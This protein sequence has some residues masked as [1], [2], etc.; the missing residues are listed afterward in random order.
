MTSVHMR[1]QKR[2]GAGGSS[3]PSGVVRGDGPVSDVGTG[4]CRISSNPHRKEP[5]CCTLGRGS[6]ARRAAELWAEAI[7]GC[8]HTREG[9]VKIC[10]DEVGGGKGG[11]FMAS[12]PRDL[13]LRRSSKVARL[14]C[15][16]F[17]KGPDMYPLALHRDRKVHRILREE[18]SFPSKY[19]SPPPQTQ[20]QCGLEV[21]ALALE[22]GLNT[23]TSSTIHTV[24]RYL[25]LYVSVFLPVLWLLW[26]LT[27][28]HHRV[29]S[30]VNV[31][32]Q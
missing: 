24:T 20:R 11:A 6:D 15:S 4:L 29:W 31:R 17:R 25:N 26:V 1:K 13:G 7:G 16:P 5:G 23:N 14:F 2:V 30:V 22:S 10:H 28:A 18:L 9:G 27:R 32:A 8:W 3:H 19:L 12:H 21:R